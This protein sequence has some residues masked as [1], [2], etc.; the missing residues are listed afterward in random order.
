MERRELSTYL[1]WVLKKFG[2]EEPKSGKAS[3]LAG[4]LKAVAYPMEERLQSIGEQW[5]SL[6]LKTSAIEG[7]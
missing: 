5:T 4:F 6:S 1:K 3:D 2:N 7:A